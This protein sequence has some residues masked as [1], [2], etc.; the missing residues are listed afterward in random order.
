M[1]PPDFSDKMTS[2]D[3]DDDDGLGSL[4]QKARSK[5]LTSARAIL[6]FVGIITLA[7]NLFFFV[8]AEDQVRRELDKEL[9]NQGLNRSTVRPDKQQ[10]LRDLEAHAV[11]ITQIVAAIFMAVGV[12]FI[13]FGF[14]IRAYPVPI[15]ITALILYIAGS[16]VSVVLADDPAKAILAG[17]WLKI[18]IIV[19]LAKSIQA[20]IAF[21][22]ERTANARSTSSGR[23]REVDVFDD[24]FRDRRHNERDKDREDDRDRDRERERRD[25]ESDRSRRDEDH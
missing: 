8:N 23:D 25:W 19:V 7:A 24:D 17:I 2:R 12:V 14:A 6:F 11:R 5:Q 22:A 3:R 15:T 16:A 21:E 13:I 4:A 20:A 9:A 10:E 18:I 1:P